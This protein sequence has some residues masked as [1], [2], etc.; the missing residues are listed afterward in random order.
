MADTNSMQL[1][2]LHC[3]YFNG[4]CLAKSD[5]AKRQ[6]QFYE[7]EYF[8]Q[9]DGGIELNGELIPFEKGSLNVRRP[10]QIVCGTP[11]YECLMIGFNAE[12]TDKA[13][14]GREL[15]TLLP[16]RFSAEKCVS[17]EKTIR[18]LYKNYTL[19][20]QTSLL[21]AMADL[22]LLLAQLKEASRVK[23][24]QKTDE[25]YHVQRALK[26]MKKDYKDTITVENIA[27]KLALSTNYFQKIF[28]QTMGV[29]PH[30]YM[31]TL[32]MDE[33]KNYLALTGIKVERIGELCGYN[34]SAYFCYAFKKQTG[35]TPREYR[36]M[37]RN[38]QN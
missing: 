22:Y 37:S 14:S 27:K 8:L 9:S 12:E 4:Y 24:C 28:R 10:G 25:N 15:L 16:F 32:R 20:T 18:R 17:M 21:L 5:M 13:V 1:Q 38:S 2:L 33:A 34:D 29:G 23:G 19:Q 3:R 30:K 11:P 31:Q 26:F 36:H 35:V 6:V 7:I